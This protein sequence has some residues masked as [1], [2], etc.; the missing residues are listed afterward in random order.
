M[1]CLDPHVPSPGANVPPA[2]LE[3]RDTMDFQVTPFGALVDMP[4]CVRMT[5]SQPPGPMLSMRV[6]GGFG[7]WIG[8]RR[9]DNL[10]RG[11]IR[12][13][14][15]LL[16]LQRRR[17][18]SRTRLC[19]LYWPEAD[20]ES[21]RNSLHVALHRVRR[22]LE[23]SGTIVYTDEGY[24]FVPAGPTWI[25]SEQFLVHAEQGAQAEARQ[26]V[27]QAI[28]QYEAG[29]ALYASDLLDEG[30]HDAG[31]AGLAQQLRDRHNQVLHRLAELYE[32]GRD[33]HACLRITLRLLSVDACNEDAHGRLM[34]CYAGLGQP[35]LVERQ[36]R[37]CLQTLREMLGVTPREE[38]VRLFRQLTSRDRPLT[39][40]SPAGAHPIP[41]RNALLPHPHT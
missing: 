30:C 2:P 11:K 16:V 13:L 4:A 18:L 21:A 40:R 15:K 37:A 34:R 41:V 28:A 23:A 1:H 6:I 14:I 20:P 9:V 5:A 39:P 19:S 33:L 24:Q 36:Y 32:A 7:L 25:D 35:Q 22:A 12:S 29:L 10:P 17:P 8:E 31:L 3:P 26:Q 38:T 27:D